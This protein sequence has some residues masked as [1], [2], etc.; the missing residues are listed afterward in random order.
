MGQTVE[1][2]VHVERL[3]RV[4]G[5]G[6]NQVTA[7]AGVDVG[8]GRGTFTA[9][10]GPSGSGKSTL[11]QIAAGLDRPTNGRV[12]VGGTDLSGLSETRLTELRRTRIGFVF[13]AFNLIGALTV[14]ENIVLPLR[15]AGVRPDRA[16][17]THVVER[18][19]LADRLHHRPA[20]LS[21]GQ[22]QRVAIARALATRPEVIFSDEPTGALDSRTA[23]EVLTL[24]RA[25]VDEH[26]QTVVMVTHDPIAASYADRVLVLADGAM[27]A[28]LPQLGAVR[29]AEHLASLD[30]RILR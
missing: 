25:V 26:G 9:V 1:P 30:G 21:G 7:L 18:V 22:Q 14:E 24:L 19:G 29:I 20:A 5:T 4:Y 27:V 28:D 12:V 23:A 6:R 15:L 2:A 8:F 16:W 13:Q 17:L 11:L 10:M 3:S